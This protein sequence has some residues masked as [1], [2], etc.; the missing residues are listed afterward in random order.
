MNPYVDP[1]ID[2]VFKR[3]FGQERNKDLLQH[4]LNAVLR[5]QPP[6][7]G[8]TLLPTQ[9][10]REHPA[11]KLSV[12]DVLAE[13]AEGRSFQVEVQL[14]RHPGLRARMLHNQSALFARQIGIGD[15]YKALT[16]VVCIWILGARV[17]P[18]ERM[19][20]CYQVIDAADGHRFSEHLE[21][22]LIELPKFRPG[23]GVLDDEESWVYFLKEAGRWRAL[24]PALDSPVMRQAMTTLLQIY[25]QD[26]DW[27]DNHRRNEALS[28]Q[29]SWEHALR[30][31][32]NELEQKDAALEQ[33]D[34]ELEQLRA[35]VRALEK[36]ER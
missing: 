17:T 2:F 15:P 21:L 18:G 36:G 31:A 7:V 14:D 20:R 10:Q 13:D 28:I 32:Q 34:A 5:P 33:K 9:L 3:L 25:E 1:L 29:A 26:K 35:R 11:D 27:F 23:S 4:F 6:I 22:H 16:P 19:H 12:I 8:L 24:P 30:E